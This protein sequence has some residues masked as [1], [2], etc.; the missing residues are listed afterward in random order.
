MKIQSLVIGA[1]AMLAAAA[2]GLLSGGRAFSSPQ[3][4]SGQRQPASGSLIEGFRL[5]EVASVA[6]AMEQL[7]G[8][9]TYMS[10][11]MRPLFPT[12]FAG[13]AVTVLMKKEE[14]KE[15]APA[16]QG[17]LDAIDA[18]P[19]GS[20]YVM[21]MP[22]GADFAGMGGLMATAMKFRGLAGA[23]IDAGIR[24]TPQIRKLQFP[25]FSRGVVPSTSINHYRF[26][27]ANVPVNCAGV[28]V[29][30]SDIIVADEDGVA[31]VPRTR[32]AAV[33][34]RA[35]ELDDTEHRMLPFIEKFRSIKEAVAKFG[36]I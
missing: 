24:D 31:V 33:L 36:R 4:G 1:A 20:V 9:R 19:P 10:H 35:Q 13:P 32:A 7:Y 29:N 2:L 27:G 30:P 28:Q 11:Q 14:H 8:E 25:V 21:V 16:S 18:A 26:A 34:R 5:V 3:A 6:D 12:K 15:G 22:E 17:M 23:I